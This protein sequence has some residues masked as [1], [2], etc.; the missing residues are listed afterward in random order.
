MN[1]LTIQS[2][3]QP[4]SHLAETQAKFKGMHPDCII[5]MQ[6]KDWYVTANEDAVTASE[7]LGITLTKTKHGEKQAG[8]PYTALDVYLPKLI[9][10]GHRVA[11]VD[12]I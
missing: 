4:V 1:N 2:Q 11:I 7:T 9:R 3:S 5:L 8:F 10:A 12:L 6:S